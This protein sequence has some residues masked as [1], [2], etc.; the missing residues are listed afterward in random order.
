MGGFGCE[1]AEEPC[2][3]RYD[4]FLLGVALLAGGGLALAWLINSVRRRMK[5]DEE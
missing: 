2:T 4:T 1:G 5:S 3:P